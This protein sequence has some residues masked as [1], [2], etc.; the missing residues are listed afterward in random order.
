VARKRDASDHFGCQA[1]ASFCDILEAGNG[2]QAFEEAK[3]YFEAIK[4]SPEQ[5]S[6]QALLKIIEGIGLVALE[7]VGVAVGALRCPVQSHINGS[8]LSQRKVDD[9]RSSAAST[10]TPPAR[11]GGASRRSISAR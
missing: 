2:Y 11:L 3:E 8:D 7:A 10:N 4:D 5:L 6:V 9:P 1:I